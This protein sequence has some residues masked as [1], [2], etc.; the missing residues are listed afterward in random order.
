MKSIVIAAIALISLNVMA[1]ISGLKK[2]K[3][4]Y[5]TIF[6]E[7]TVFR[8]NVWKSCCFDHDLR[9]WFGGTWEDELH[10][11]K[12]L[13]SC[14]SQKAGSFYGNMMYY[15]VR[16]GHQSPKKHPSHWGWG[17]IDQN[18][19]YYQKLSKFDRMQIKAALRLLGLDAEYIKSFIKQYS[20]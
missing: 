18:R 7:G 2:F 15:G 11:D 19:E 3:T 13:R 1:D 9:Y 14:V 16:L 5:C 8:P 17:W 4:D 20:L 10:A 12:V 6:S